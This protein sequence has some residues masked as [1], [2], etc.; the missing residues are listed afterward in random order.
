MK[1]KISFPFF[2][3]TH[4]VKSVSLKKKLSCCIFSYKLGKG[5]PVTLRVGAVQKHH[6]RELYVFKVLILTEGICAMK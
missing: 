2:I 6:L 3:C 1:G 5:C 4:F